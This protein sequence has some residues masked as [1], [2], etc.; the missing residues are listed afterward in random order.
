MI[1]EPVDFHPMRVHQWISTCGEFGRTVNLALLSLS[2]PPPP[3]PPPAATDVS[4]GP[5][6][7]VDGDPGVLSPPLFSSSLFPPPPPGVVAPHAA[8]ACGLE[9]SFL[10]KGVKVAVHRSNNVG[11]ASIT[12]SKISEI[13]SWKPNPP[14]HPNTLAKSFPVPNGKIATAVF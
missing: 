10:G 6:I 2:S 1:R 4:M 7:G 8:Y 5:N 3:P 12:C 13:I 14:P 11:C 9:S